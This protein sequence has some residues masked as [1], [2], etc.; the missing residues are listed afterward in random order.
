LSNQ[1]S[2]RHIWKSNWLTS[3]AANAADVVI[4]RI[5]VGP[6]PGNSAQV[7]VPPCCWPAAAAGI[8]PNEPP[9]PVYWVVLLAALH[10]VIAAAPVSASAV[11]VSLGRATL[12]GSPPPCSVLLVTDVRG[13]RKG[14]YAQGGKPLPG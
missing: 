11:I 9:G 6:P 12:T 10:A 7:T 8:V 1:Y 4:G 3:L 13:R 14:K 5:H 2:G